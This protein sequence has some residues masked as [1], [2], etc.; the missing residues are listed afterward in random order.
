VVVN[1]MIMT[2]FEILI[3]I[4]LFLIYCAIKSS[5]SKMEPNQ[6][7]ST[8]LEICALIKDLNQKVESLSKQQPEIYEIEKILKNISDKLAA[9][10]DISTRYS[11]RKLLDDKL[12][13]I[14]EEVDKSATALD[15]IE[16]N[17]DFIERKLRGE[18]QHH[19]L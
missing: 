12:S 4:A 8:V 2:I 14:W 15:R 13:Q 9:E 10:F 11:L 7:T 18:N 3:L 5:K 6:D 16:G 1:Q 19:P 17:V